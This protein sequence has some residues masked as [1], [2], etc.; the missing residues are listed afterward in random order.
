MRDFV[1]IGAQRRELQSG[2]SW[3]ECEWVNL[4]RIEEVFAA[5]L[6]GEEV[7]NPGEK[8]VSTK[9]PGVTRSLHAESL[10]QVQPVLAG[11]AWKDVRAADPVEYG[12]DLYQHV[13]AVAL[14]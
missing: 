13:A 4:D 5:L 1:G 6:A 12:R 11:L 9:L 3:L 2:L 8:P 7:I 10:C 14:G